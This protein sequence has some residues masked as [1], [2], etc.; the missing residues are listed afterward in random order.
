MT[1]NDLMHCLHSAMHIIPASTLVYHRSPYLPIDLIFGLNDA[2]RCNLY[3]KKL[4]QKI[5]YV[6]KNSKAA[7]E[8]Q[9]QYYD[10]NS[11]KID[12]NV[13]DKVYVKFPKIQL[14]GISRKFA[15]RWKGPYTIMEYQAP[16]VKLHMERVDCWIH[17]NRCK[18]VVSRCEGRRKDRRTSIY[19]DKRSDSPQYREI[20]IDIPLETTHNE[21]Y[22]TRYGRIV[23]PP[24]KFGNVVDD[25]P[26]GG[27]IDGAV[28]D[29]FFDINAA[30]DP[31]PIR[32]AYTPRPQTDLKEVVVKVAFE[33]SFQSIL[34]SD[35]LLRCCDQK[36]RLNIE[37]SLGFLAEAVRQQVLEAQLGECPDM[38][39]G[40]KECLD[41]HTYQM[42]ARLYYISGT[43]FETTKNTS[44]F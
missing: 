33:D 12:L 34:D 21:P 29:F 28:V 7:R 42:R 44:R 30:E 37:S 9:K 17:Q 24:S 10:R 3:R 15:A 31:A 26:S 1:T 16:L 20:Y 19:H 6:A 40:F 36:T 23:R 35:V 8:R 14:N 41:L 11:N 2:A 22:K 18:L 32:R 38:Q 25:S 5:N 4:L 39:N 43:T 13:G 27:G